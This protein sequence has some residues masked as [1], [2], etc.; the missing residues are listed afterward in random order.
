VQKII[1]TE[2]YCKP[3]NLHP[4]T[5]TRHIQDIRVGILTIREKWERLLKLASFDKWEGHYLDDERSVKIDKTLGKDVFL[6]VHANVLPTPSIINKIKKLQHGEFLS[7]KDE[8]GIAY[9]FSSKE[10]LSSHKIKIIRSIEHHESLKV[11]HYPWQI[12]QLNDWAIREDFKLIT[13]RRKSKALSKTNKVIN[14]SQI[15]MEEGAKVEHCILN[16]ATGPIYIGKNAEIQEGSM[17]RGPFALCEASVVKMGSKIYGATT[18][19][20]YC[21]A[22]GEIKNTV[23][24]GYSN[25]AHDGYLGDSVIGEWCN[26]GAGTSNSNLKNNCGE[27]LYWVH[28]DKQQVSA[29]NKGGLLMGD[30]S[31]SAINTSFNTGTVVGICSN[32]FAQ[33]LTP[34]Y[35]PHFTWGSDGI[36][37][38]KLN[39]ALAD[40]DKWKQLKGFSISEREKQVLTE[41]YKKF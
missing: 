29:G 16:A 39:H 11:L 10:V 2:E 24:M 7:V 4:F 41:I 12:F 36:T 35:I 3:Q 40:I 23:L 20:P 31:K 1:F 17:I 14:A 38:Y 19:G 28:A 9:K 18:I 5:L 13:T 8:G 30:Y 27:V 34:K 26:V 33:G 37:K 22:G 32:V 21:L 15:F 6:M 25:K